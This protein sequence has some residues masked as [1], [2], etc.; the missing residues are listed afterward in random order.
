MK[1]CPKCKDFTYEDSVEECECGTKLTEIKPADVMG[2]NQK[3]Y[4]EER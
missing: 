1:E 4:L 2:I 3:S